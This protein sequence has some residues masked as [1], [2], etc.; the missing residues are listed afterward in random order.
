MTEIG[1][2]LRELR[3]KK[4]LSIDDIQE[5]TKI[6]SRYI[7]AIEEGNLDK[8]PGQF[9]AKAFIKAYS[10]VVELDPAILAEYQEAIPSQ[11]FENIQI[12]PQYSLASDRRSRFGKWLF[13]SL[14][15]LLIG[16]TL[17]FVYIFYVSYTSE[18]TK[19]LPGETID[20]N[21][22]FEV[23][24]KNDQEK[25]N[26][27]DNQSPP[28][29]SNKVEKPSTDIQITKVST[30]TYKYKPYDVY[31]VTVNEGTNVQIQLKFNDR[32]WFDIR[33]G[34]NDGKQLATA[35]LGVGEETQMFTLND[36]LW[37]HLGNASGA[38]IYIN[39]KQIK[40][41]SETGPKYISIIKKQQ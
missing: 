33:D 9:Y 29:E 19:E 23:I 35:N 31:E 11:E 8:L 21:K 37:I 28:Q 26:I 18:Q 4:G 7:Q 2:L 17:L 14:V 40:A 20:N 15:Y 10:E 30:S 6:R 36:Q 24:D 34:G 27:T 38:D 12:K 41:G 25:E 5:I 16:L 3:L 22:D 39:D 1:E 32:C 13:S